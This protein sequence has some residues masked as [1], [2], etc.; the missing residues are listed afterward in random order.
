M[1]DEYLEL[2]YRTKSAELRAE[3]VEEELIDYTRSFAAQLASYKNQV[4]ETEKKRIFMERSSISSYASP[5]DPYNLMSAS[6][7]PILKKPES[8]P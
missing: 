5:L 3:V 1:E 7:V 4:L 8:I 6:D 2:I